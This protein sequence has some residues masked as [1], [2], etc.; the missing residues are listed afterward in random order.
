[1]TDIA[2]ELGVQSY[3]FRGFKEN[4]KVVDLVKECG[5]DAIE[6]C[7]VH[8]DFADESGFD[9]VIKLYSDAGVRIVSI[10][11]NTLECDES[12]RPL[13]EFVKKAGAKA[14]AV[15]FRT[16]SYPDGLAAAEKLAE[17]YDV[18][19][20][21]HNHG[22]RDWLG[23]AQMLR[24]VFERT[25]PRVGLCL[26]TAWAMAAMEDPLK[27]AET[28]GER[29]HGLHIKD[30]TFKPTGR[31]EDVVVG[32]GNLDLAKLKEVLEKVGFSGYAVLEYEADVEDP[33]PAL[34]KCVAAV[35]A[36][37]G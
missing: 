14:M 28:F 26:D 12:D 7:G 9:D 15:S 29:L 3:C 37:A 10:G 31:P 21:I 34:T 13:F 33:V 18:N 27:M 11:C 16:G 35:R 4:G 22:G 1:V 30:F 32:Q 6:L 36:A 24:A 20:G 17:E 25:G 8:V 23:N 5:L 19:L 2:K